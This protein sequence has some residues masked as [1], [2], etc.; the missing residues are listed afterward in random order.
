MMLMQTP[1]PPPCCQQPPPH[2]VYLTQQQQ[3]PAK[4]NIPAPQP[5]HQHQAYQPTARKRSKCGR[6]PHN[7]TGGN[8]GWN[9]GG[10]TYY[11]QGGHH[12]GGYGGQGPGGPTPPWQQQNIRVTQEGVIPIQLK[13]TITFTINNRADMIYTRQDG[14]VTP[15]PEKEH[16]YPIWADI[17]H[18]Q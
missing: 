8:N 5:Q 9:Q 6:G 15:I 14:N 11:H 1:P 4:I 13:C 17:R 12:T 16:T 2:T 10:Q 18:T 7:A 3:P